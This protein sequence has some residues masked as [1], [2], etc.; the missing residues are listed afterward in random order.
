M[1]RPA[2]TATTPSSPP[3]P[4][5]RSWWDHHANESWREREHHK[6]D[7]V[8]ENNARIAHGLQHVAEQRKIR[9]AE[10]AKVKK[11]CSSRID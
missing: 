8:V 9:Q 2:E 7:K 10:L 6:A 5:P 3:P 11:E 1:R 4:P